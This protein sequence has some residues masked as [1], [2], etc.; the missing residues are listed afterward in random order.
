MI[1]IKRSE[2]EREEL[3]AVDLLYGVL[4]EHPDYDM[5]YV[6]VSDAHLLVFNPDSRLPEITTVIGQ[7][8]GLF[9]E[10]APGTEIN[11]NLRQPGIR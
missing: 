2:K 3:Y 5:I 9:K 10:C 4:Y 1:K 6:R 8:S 11:F 7:G